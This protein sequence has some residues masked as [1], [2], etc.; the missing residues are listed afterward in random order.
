M[1]R[2][3]MKKAA[4][5]SPALLADVTRAVGELRFALGRLAMDGRLTADLMSL[6]TMIDRTRFDLTS[7][8]GESAFVLNKDAGRLSFRTEALKRVVVEADRLAAEVAGMSGLERT[9]VVQLS[10]NLFVM[11]ELMHVH[12]NFPDFDVVAQVKVGLP[13]FGLPILDVTAD[14]KAAWICARVEF[15]RLGLEEESDFFKIFANTLIQSYV[16]GAF[17]F[18][19]TGRPEKIQRVLG[20]LISAALIQARVEGRLVSSRV[21][22]GWKPES[23]MIAFDVS[24]SNT[25]NAIVLDEVSGVLF[26]EYGNVSPSLLGL[27]WTSVGSSPVGET[28][29][30]IFRA[31]IAIGAVAVAPT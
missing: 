17:V 2:R 22:R 26:A 4:T 12:Q 9:R 6:C 20:L 13:K 7:A 16:I 23:P 10:V 11:H 14:T 31:L 25:L 8:R 15:E 27:I 5:R 3:S 28:L 29:G 18:D 30:L 24:A 19:V 21:Y 1:G